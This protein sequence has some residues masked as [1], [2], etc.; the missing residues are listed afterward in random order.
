M[1]IVKN[2]L[3]IIYLISAP[4]LVYL[5][6]RGLRQIDEAKNQVLATKESRIINAKRESYKIAADKCEYYLT[7]IIPL[8][9]ILDRAIRENNIEYFEKSTVTMTKNG[10]VTKQIF[11]DEDERFKILDLPTLDVYNR[12][13]GFSIFFVSGVAD[14]K[15][16]FLTIGNTFC[17]SVKIYLPHL[18]RLSGQKYFNNVLELY[19]IWY[20]RLEKERL[21]TEKSNIDKA[22]NENNEIIIKTIGT[23]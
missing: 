11:K 7:T 8:I 17:Y 1:L 9:N 10:M 23:E 21:E 4:V 6:Y 20:N 2:I 5:A 19:S 18:L 14:E 13:E 12:L 16:G 22:L 3:E 15:V